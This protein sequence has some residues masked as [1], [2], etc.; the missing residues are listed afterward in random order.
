MKKAVHNILAIDTTA[1]LTSVALRTHGQL[2]SQK[3][4]A[5]EKNTTVILPLIEKLCQQAQLSACD[6]DAICFAKGPGSFTGVRVASAIVQGIAFASNAAVASF[7]SLALLA[8]AAA[9]KYSG[10]NIM[11]LVASDAR[12]GEVY[13]ATYMARV[14]SCGIEKLEVIVKDHLAA[15]SEIIY[16][17]TIN[18]CL[19]LKIGNGWDVYQAEI[20]LAEHLCLAFKNQTKK[21]PSYDAEI[22]LDA[23]Y[24]LPLLDYFQM[25]PQ[26]YQSFAEGDLWGDAHAAKP[27]YLRNNVAKKKSQR[28]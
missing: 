4:T 8:V 25:H 21:M 28:R 16:P 3:S 23:A 7:S 2:I 1:E 22:A 13:A 26:R 18:D 20:K 10:H 24:L 15:P 14:T 9:Y 19:L 12:M 5:G 27:L 11:L 17:Q 6:L